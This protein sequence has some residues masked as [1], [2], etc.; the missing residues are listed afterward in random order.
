MSY[1]EYAVGLSP[2]ESETVDWTNNGTDTTVTI[3][4][5][6][7]VDGTTYYGSIRAYNSEGN[8]SQAYSGDGITIDASPP[9]SGT[10]IEGDT[11]DIDYTSN[12]ETLQL[13]WSGFS[14]ENSGISHYE[15][16][17]GRSPGADDMVSFT[18]TTDTSAVLEADLVDGTTYYCI[19][20][21]YDVAGNVSGD[22]VGDGVMLDISA[23]EAGTV[24]DGFEGDLEFTAS[25]TTLSAT[26]SGFSDAGSGIQFYEYAAGTTSGG[27]DMTDWTGIDLDTTMADSSLV[28]VGG[29]I[30]HVSV[31][32]TDLAQ[33]LSLIHI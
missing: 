28:L 3:T 12:A 31:R 22:I 2:G 19:V 15:Y 18:E 27:T 20:R 33:N 11:I 4:G 13:T 17:L 10:I 14:D 7:L 30:Y 8:P 25:T 5:L 1:Y 24:V 23:P 16:G 29:Q 9:I 21:A 6:S 26:W 32:A